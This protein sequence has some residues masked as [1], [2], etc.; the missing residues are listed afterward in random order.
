MTTVI[1]LDDYHCLDRFGRKE[2]K[3]T[4]LDPVAQ[5]FDL[6]YEQTK[7]LK[8]GKPVQ[9]PIYNHVSGLLDPP[10]EIKSPNVRCFA[11]WPPSLADEGHSAT[12]A[13]MAMP[14]CSDRSKLSVRR[15]SS[16]LPLPLV[17]LVKA[18]A[19]HSRW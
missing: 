14:H 19:R 9:K 6:M 11:S 12:A 13:A 17:T 16:R 1:C 8:E 4:A 2:K 5:D 3:V 15:D 18:L 7:S 10:E